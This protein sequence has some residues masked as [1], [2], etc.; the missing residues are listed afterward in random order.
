MQIKNAAKY[1]TVA[2]IS[3]ACFGLVACDN[4]V[5]EVE[6]NVA[7]LLDEAEQYVEQARIPYTPETMD[8]VTVKED[9]WLG[10][11]SFKMTGGEPFPLALEA[12]DALTV[13]FAEPIKLEDLIIDLREMTGS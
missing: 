10:Q 3:A 8:T 6:D 5:Q 4:H 9:I 7:V 12:P 2:I 13:S 1:L 11:N